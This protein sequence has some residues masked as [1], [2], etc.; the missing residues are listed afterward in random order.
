MSVF[1]PQLDILYEDEHILLL[2]K[3]PGMVVHP[4]GHEQ[5]N[6]LASQRSSRWPASFLAMVNS[7]MADAPAEDNAFLSVFKPQLDI[8]YECLCFRYSPK[9]SGGFGT[10]REGGDGP[11]YPV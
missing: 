10:L 7:F 9:H 2:N 11:G 6:T 8:V 5:V 1:K 3:R 4:D